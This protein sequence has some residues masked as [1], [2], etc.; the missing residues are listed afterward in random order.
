[1]DL[2]E[3][4]ST[5]INRHPWETVRAKVLQRILN[6]IR[7]DWKVNR[8]LDI[9]CGDGYTIDRVCMGLGPVEIDAVDI[10]LTQEQIDLFSTVNKNINFYSK[11]ELLPHKAYQLITLFDVLE[12]VDNDALF[13]SGILQNYAN[14]RQTKFFIT[15]PAFNWLFGRHDVSLKH[16]RR[17]N[18]KMMHVF[19]DKNAL[20]IKEYGFIFAGLLPLRIISLLWEKLTP[21]KQYTFRGVGQWRYGKI[22]TK[23]VE[24]FL[25]IDCRLALIANKSGFKIP[26]LTLWFICEPLQ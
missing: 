22:I 16:H 8:V 1:M 26:G 11:F 7:K 9:G 6:S 4:K 25:H 23:L 19:A 15:V 3:R 14:G 12:H 20:K 21:K 2:C 18:R 10:N 13:L 17:Y 24:A 5:Q